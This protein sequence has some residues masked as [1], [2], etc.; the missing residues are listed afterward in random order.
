MGGRG[1]GRVGAW[2]KADERGERRGPSLVTRCL[3]L[4]CSW[5]YGD[6]HLTNHGIRHYELCMSPGAN[7]TS[8]KES[9]RT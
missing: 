5:L 6:M 2:P 3:S 7:F 9:R 4:D 1:E 8:L